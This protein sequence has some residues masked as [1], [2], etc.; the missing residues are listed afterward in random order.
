MLLTILYQSGALYVLAGLLVLL[1]LL[2]LTSTG[3][4]PCRDREFVTA[5][6]WKWLAPVPDE[7]RQFRAPQGVRDRL[8]QGLLAI[9]TT[10]YDSRVK[11]AISRIRRGV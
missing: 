4:P 5:F 10:E 11:D 7:V 8:T 6:Q 9:C 3:P 1:I 2:V